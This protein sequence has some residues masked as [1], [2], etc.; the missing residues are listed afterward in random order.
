M[1]SRRIRM[2][3]LALG[4]LV[5]VGAGWFGL[6]RTPTSPQPPADAD[7][8]D[9]TPALD[10]P[11]ILRGGNP[12]SHAA[13][14]APASTAAPTGSED[15][16]RPAPG[17]APWARGLDLPP[18]AI[19][20]EPPVM[21]PEHMRYREAAANVGPA[22][23]VAYLERSMVLLDTSIEALEARHREDP[24]S[25]RG[26]RLAIRLDRLRLSRRERRVELDAM[27][28]RLANESPPAEEPDAPT[29]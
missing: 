16:P 18:P 13:P 3:G 1:T 5:A 6:R 2:W 21:D 15:G 17:A 29:P 25:A 14:P 7:V 10:A 26:R 8:E 27:R 11:P 28:T 12:E 22:D 19:P 20:D 4:A 24:E 9:S 23:Q